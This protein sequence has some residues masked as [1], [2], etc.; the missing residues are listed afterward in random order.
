[1]YLVIP[2][3]S[4]ATDGGPVV[5]LARGAVTGLVAGRVDFESLLHQLAQRRQCRFGIATVREFYGATEGNTAVMN[6]ENKVG[7]VGRMPLRAGD[8]WQR[9]PL[10]LKTIL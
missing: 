6:L 9:S 3:P 2:P 8:T 7:S 1:M 4:G 10:K 5:D